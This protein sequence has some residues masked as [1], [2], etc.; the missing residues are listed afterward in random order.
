MSSLAASR[1][2][3]RSLERRGSRLLALKEMKQLHN[4][5]FEPIREESRNSTEHKRA[6]ESLIF[7]T[8]KKN[9]AVKARDVAPMA[10][11]KKG[12]ESGRSFKP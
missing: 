4:P 10:V 2:V 1:K 9:G 7:L 3:F 5:C 12:H 11:P 8:K 6:L